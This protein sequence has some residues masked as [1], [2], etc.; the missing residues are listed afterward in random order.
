MGRTQE[1]K[2]SEWAMLLIGPALMAA[3]LDIFTIPNDIA[4]GGVSGMATALAALIPVSIGVL[5]FL[6]NIPLFW[7]AWRVL[8][9]RPLLKTLIPT[10]LLSVYIDLFALFLPA[11]ENNIL[12]AAVLGGVGSGI[13]MGM[14]FLCGA[15]SGGTDLLSLMLSR[16]LPHIPIGKLLMGI[17][18][19]VVLFAVFVFRDIDVA[20]Y[21][22]VTIFVTSKMID[23]FLEGVDF[24]KVV[25]VV[26]EK[27]EEIT[28]AL[29]REL[30]RGVTL[31][32][33]KGGY[34]GK[35]K[36]MLM[37]VTR[38]NELS[39]TLKLIKMTDR[40]AF[41]FVLNA[42]EVHGEGFKPMDVQ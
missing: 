7:G 16:R 40:E 33:A 25:Y 20:L 17:D 27:G 29:N 39:A 37:T 35:E 31:L 28:S 32:S 4:P 5:S 12:L 2:L 9:F 18:A 38:R 14:L 36:Q 23:S 42:A 21:S 30:D 3:S 19:C 6:L 11:Y 10:V 13:G 8:G 26:T 22:G 24:A 15:S 34:T 1:K 41:L